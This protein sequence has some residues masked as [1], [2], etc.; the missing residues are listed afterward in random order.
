VNGKKD[1]RFEDSTGI[2]EWVADDRAIVQFHSMEDVEA[3]KAALTKVVN[4]W[5]ISTV[6]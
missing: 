2:L 4:D 1:F 3:K 5:M 6:E